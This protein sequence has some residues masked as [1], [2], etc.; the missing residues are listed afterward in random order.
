MKEIR[1]NLEDPR[2]FERVTPNSLSTCEQETLAIIKRFP[3]IT[4]IEIGKYLKVHHSNIGPRVRKLADRDLI[5]RK[6][7]RL[8][9]ATGSVHRAFALY[10]KKK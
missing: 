8:K 1:V 4:I 6:Q 5:E 2:I 7:I 10:V 9:D 3:G